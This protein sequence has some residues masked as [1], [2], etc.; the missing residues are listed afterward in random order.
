[1]NEIN[2]DKKEKSTRGKFVDL[3]GQKFGR[4]TVIEKTNKRQGGRIIW[5]CRCDCGNIVDVNGT[6]LRNGTTKSCGCY[7]REKSSKQMINLN[8]RIKK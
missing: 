3:R 8:K 5:K 6:S 7:R 4:L 1:M 2:L